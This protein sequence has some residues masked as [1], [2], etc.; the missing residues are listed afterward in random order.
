MAAATN[1]P[2][3]TEPV[4]AFMAWSNS[5]VDFATSPRP[6]APADLGATRNVIDSIADLIDDDALFAEL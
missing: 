1:T 5:G 2:A 3:P 6:A 4:A